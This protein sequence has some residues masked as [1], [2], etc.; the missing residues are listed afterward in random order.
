LDREAVID[1][2]TQ[3]KRVRIVASKS[4]LKCK[5]DEPQSSNAPEII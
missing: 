1:L 2:A 4:Y 3:T 5:L